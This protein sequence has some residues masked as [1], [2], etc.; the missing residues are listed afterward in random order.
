MWAAPRMVRANS[1]SPVDT[2]YI[3]CDCLPYIS[4]SVRVF[5]SVKTAASTTAQQLLCSLQT[6]TREREKNGTRVDTLSCLLAKHCSP[7]VLRGAP[8]YA[9]WQLRAPLFTFGVIAQRTHRKGEA[10]QHNL[11]ARRFFLVQYIYAF[12]VCFYYY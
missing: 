12:C 9:T 6:H 11:V 3:R 4:L 1:W 10:R 5:I 7:M 2:N 8:D